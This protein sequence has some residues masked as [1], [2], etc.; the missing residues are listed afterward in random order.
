MSTSENILQN[1]AIYPNPNKGDFTVQFNSSSNNEIKIE[2]YDMRGR[3]IFDNN[4]E[5]TGLFR[6]NIQLNNLQS[7]VYLVNVQDGKKK[8]VKRI[9]I[10]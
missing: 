4:Y 5:N 6:Q 10:E 8:E 7:G 2:V 1:F 9:I 3:R